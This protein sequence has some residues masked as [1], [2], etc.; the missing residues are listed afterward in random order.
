MRLTVDHLA[1]P[2]R[3]DRL[4]ALVIFGVC[5]H[6]LMCGFA[7]GQ[8]VVQSPTRSTA[9]PSIP[10]T[11]HP[12]RTPQAIALASHLKSPYRGSGDAT[13]ILD[14]LREIS[15][16]YEVF[17]W[18][19]R[20]IASDQEIAI[21][22]QDDRTL[23]AAIDEVAEQ[24]HAGVAIYDHVIAIVPQEN[25]E[26]I[27]VGYWKLFQATSGALVRLADGGEFGWED[28]A[29]FTQVWDSFLKKY[30]RLLADPERSISDG[31]VRKDLQRD[32]TE[33]RSD[34]LEDI[35]R[36][37][38]F[39]NTSPAAIAFSLMSGFDCALQLDS[40]DA[41]RLQVVPLRMDSASSDVEWDYRD[42]IEKVGR[43]RW[44]E[45]RERWPSVEVSRRDESSPTTW[46]V[47]A[48]PRAHWELVAYL[49]PK[50]EPKKPKSADRSVKRYTG[51][52]RGE[53]Q[54]I[55]EGFATQ[56]SLRL[57]L[58]KLPP[59]LARKE[60]DIRFEQASTDEI[61]AKLSEASGIRIRRKDD[62]LIV[63]FP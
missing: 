22:P 23:L 54:R 39:R 3:Y 9:R 50:W 62:E 16:Q 10:S 5:L 29:R 42:E 25:S 37:A 13:P 59:Q 24:L 19:D 51:A 43:D 57:S 56:S 1:T 32:V 61:I 49:A 18:L 21:P 44:K 60:I 47:V 27:E 36:A 58:P 48:S 26:S 35:W 7:S 12:Y 11:L 46:R 28:G 8:P 2:S 17:I 52:Y 63:E 45:W 30:P 20:S 41:G 15:V 34:R 53:M 31:L 6:S 55:L 38:R 4:G 33:A 14:W 40:G